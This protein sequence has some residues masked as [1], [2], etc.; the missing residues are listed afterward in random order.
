[1]KK[2]VQNSRLESDKE[3]VVR[4]VGLLCV[5]TLHWMICCLGST[6][7]FYSVFRGRAPCHSVVFKKKTSNSLSFGVC[8]IF[9]GR[10]C[11]CVCV[12][13]RVRSFGNI[14]F[15]FLPFYFQN[16]RRKKKE[17]RKKRDPGTVVN[18]LRFPAVYM[19]LS[20]SGH[21]FL[22]MSSPLFF[23]F[24]FPFQ[25]WRL[26]HAF[27]FVFRPK[28]TDQNKKNNKNK[29]LSSYVCCCSSTQALTYILYLNSALFNSVVCIWVWVPN[30]LESGANVRD[31]AFHSLHY[32]NHDTTCWTVL[33]F[34]SLL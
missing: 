29:I 10:E 5:Y 31:G 33:F 26:L 20:K 13:V 27:P 32:M 11:V 19:C 25:L 7:T 15:C 8:A 4:C 30:F 28:S 21:L 3:S 2:T 22:A 17:P 1:M 6:L 14:I 9:N 23:L 34:L 16:W 18:S 24:S 12:C